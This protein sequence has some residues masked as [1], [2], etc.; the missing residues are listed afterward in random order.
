M[1]KLIPLLLQLT[2]VLGTTAQQYPVDCRVVVS[3][4]YSGRWLDYANSPQKI[5]VQLL[6][7]DLSKPSLEVSVRIRL[8]SPAG[9]LIQN[10]E[11]FMS[12]SPITLT[13]GVTRTLGGSELA[14]NF[15]GSSLEVQGIDL[16]A[17]LQGDYLPSG[18]YEWEV[19]AYEHFRDRQVSNTA[20]A[21]MV[22]NLNRPPLLNLP[23]N[24]SVQP[25]SQPQNLL[26]SW[27]PRH[28]L[29]TGLVTYSLAL[30]EIPEGEDPQDYVLNG[31]IPYRIVETTQTSFSYGPGEVP[32]NP[33][34]VYAWQVQVQAD[35]SGFENQGYSVVQ[36]F[37]YGYP[38]C[39]TPQNP[40]GEADEHSILFS[41]DE[42]P[43]TKGYT[44]IVNGTQQVVTQNR[45]LLQGVQA[46]MS[47]VWSVATRCEGGSSSPSEQQT[48]SIPKEEEPIW[49][50]DPDLVY[51]NEQP[52]S[53]FEPGDEESLQAGDEVDLEDILNTPIKIFI[54][55]D[56]N[57]TLPEGLPSNLP[58]LA[59]DA[60]I[61]QFQQ[62]LKSRKPTCSGIT[63]GYSCGNHQNAPH[64][65]G[66]I[67]PVN[68]GDEVAM[69]SM[70]MTIVSIDAAGN[71][72]G[73]IQVPMFGNV[74]LGVT[75]HGIKVAEGGCV[76][77]GRAETSSVSAA[78]LNDKLRAELQKAYAIF[79]EATDIA[80]ENAGVIAE[81]YNNFLDVLNGVKNKANA[82]LDK[83]NSGGAPTKTEVEA[84]K[85]LTE[86]ATA[87]MEAS[88]QAIKQAY[89]EQINKE[90]EETVKA[91]I[92]KNKAD[93]AGLTDF[94]P[95]N[96]PN[97]VISVK[98]LASTEPVVIQQAILSLA[99]LTVEYNG[100]SYARGKTINIISPTNKVSVRG[101]FSDETFEWK[102]SSGSSGSTSPIEISFPDSEFEM[103]LEVIQGNR[104][105]NVVLRKKIVT[106]EGL[107]AYDGK[108]AK[109]KADSKKDETLYFVGGGDA[110]GS[111]VRRV[112]FKLTTNAMKEDFS[113]DEPQFSTKSLK[114][115][116]EYFSDG[117]LNYSTAG[118]CYS[119]DY[120]FS[121]TYP[122]KWSSWARPSVS[123]FNKKHTVDLKFVKAYYGKVSYINK[124]NPILQV[125]DEFNYVIN[126]LETFGFPCKVT[127]F[128]SSSDWQN[129]PSDVDLS[130]A[131]YNKEIENSRH[132][133]DIKDINL[134][135]SKL[136]VFEFK[137]SKAIGWGSFSLGD[138][139]AS[140]SCTPE[141]SVTAR[142]K[143][144]FETKQG[145]WSG[146]GN[147][148][149]PVKTE[150]GLEKKV[151]GIFG[152][153]ISVPIVVGGKGEYPNEGNFKEVAFYAYMDRTNV[154]I[155]ANVDVGVF[156]EKDIKLSYLLFDT[157]WKSP[158]RVY[159][160]DDLTKE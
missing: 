23:A 128:K 134:K 14:E 63:T 131:T 116:G 126:K 67:I 70:L 152:Y 124:I 83:L 155:T 154:N 7:R 2:F 130:A 9:V 103:T 84:L 28:T 108:N 109:R 90:M 3:P 96:R 25:V 24:G 92:S 61:E 13:P 95:E 80:L 64:Y 115:N 1:K 132:I 76:V 119:K 60:N 149:I 43:G 140:L 104:K 122:S 102:L 6:L 56:E 160:L 156:G 145:K 72:E 44:L 86:Q 133:E 142:H 15:N 82:L 51:V 20:S 31:G 66:P 48:V 117:D 139:Y 35:E 75:L 144:N 17:L 118:C 111:E 65:D 91:A 112:N 150:F 159:N 53:V 106:F 52:V 85:K 4:P 10:P 8:K 87:Q 74:K 157:Q 27:T 49:Y 32:L 21:R 37:R 129:R 62:A 59:P 114:L 93:I 89:G 45:Y 30:Y 19:T 113:G 138:F 41:W 33:G 107:V 39:E 110:V 69:N 147:I 22:L 40:K 71:G 98:S 46:G 18:P 127:F 58:V 153:N 81:T 105:T 42:V 121:Y 54:P 77:A 73:L 99:P 135:L 151:D 101:L 120:A 79:E 57:G 146:A 78:L 12:S 136:K 137:C 143:T 97:L 36:S 26:F 123:S 88:L 94:K 125:F 38:S 148:A 11:G 50:S 16:L 141:I 34:K 47:Y 100:K 158:K 5:K 29:V 55:E 68:A